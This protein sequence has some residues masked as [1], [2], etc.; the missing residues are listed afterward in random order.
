MARIV[1]AGGHGKVALQLTRI[2]TDRGDDVVG[3]IRD[4]DQ[5]PELR[6]HGAVPAVLDLESA[7]VAELAEVVAGADAV[8]FAAGAGPGSGAARKETVDHGAAVLLR[9]AAIEAGVSRYV[10]VSAMATDDPPEGDEVF[11]VYLRAKAQADRDLAD[12]SLDWTIVRPGSLTD[13]PGTGMVEIGRTVRRGE[14]PRA[15]VAAV[16]AAVLS[17]DTT[18]GRVFEVVYG[19][20]PIAEAVGKLDEATRRPPEP[21]V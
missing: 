10:M 5:G 19:D 11:D 9:D 8:V 18:I 12:S 7:S 3:I 17:D 1:I 21:P 14:V 6:D 15:D 20:T 13:E 4:P 16:L 2:L